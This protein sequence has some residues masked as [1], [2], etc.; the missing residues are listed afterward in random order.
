MVLNR[1]RINNSKMKTRLKEETL[2]TSTPLKPSNIPRTIIST[3]AL[4]IQATVPT[5]QQI[6]SSILEDLDIK[7]N[8]VSKI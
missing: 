4:S 3:T 2:I 5:H 7:N 6:Q 8:R 1:L